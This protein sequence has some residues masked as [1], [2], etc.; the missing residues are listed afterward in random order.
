MSPQSTWAGVVED[1]RRAQSPRG[2]TQLGQYS[3]EGVRLIE[4]ALRAG[5][6][7]RR[8]LISERSLRHRDR[9]VGEL[10]NQL[11]QVRCE[12]F[13]VPEGVMLELAEGRNGGLLIALCDLPESL[14]L[15]EVKR[16][17]MAGQGPVLVLVDVEEPGNVGALIRTGLACAVS[18]VV[19][20]GVTDPFH[21]KAVRTSMGSVFKVPI[22]R[23]FEPDPVIEGLEQLKRYAATPEQGPAPWQREL[24]LVSALFVGNESQGLKPE[25]IERL[26]ERLTIPMPAGV[27]SFSVNAAAAILLYELQR[28]AAARKEPPSASG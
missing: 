17:A 10:L 20:V 26:D 15:D 11:E 13:A 3:V 24:S 22:A 8:L 6:P 19:T 16:R 1:V 2:R 4:R 18:A 5:Q 14:T 25:L 23:S 9:R 12:V 28:Q 21:P 27:D 7:P